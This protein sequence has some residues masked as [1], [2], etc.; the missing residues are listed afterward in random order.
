[1]AK[2]LHQAEVEGWAT[3]ERGPPQEVREDAVLEGAECCWELEVKVGE[4]NHMDVP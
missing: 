4:D 1:M 2:E 3:L